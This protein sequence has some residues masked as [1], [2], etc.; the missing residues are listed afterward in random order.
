MPLG[1]LETKETDVPGTCQLSDDPNQKALEV[2]K[3]VDVS[4]LKHGKGKCAS[5]R[6]HLYFKLI[7]HFAPVD[8]DI[9]LV[10]QPSDDPYL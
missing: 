4:A 5:P 2:Y 9:I 7:R 6:P 3:G 10:P 1:I 8:S